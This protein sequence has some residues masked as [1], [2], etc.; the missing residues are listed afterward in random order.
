MQRRIFLRLVAQGAVLSSC[1]TMAS[2]Q[3]A[4]TIPHGLKGAVAGADDVLIIG[5]GMA[6]LAAAQALKVAGKTV[7]IIEA[8]QRVG[9][10]VWSWRNWGAPIELVP[11]GSKQLLATRLPRSLNKPI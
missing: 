10:R 7:R 4:P 11:I 6:G 2:Q 8:R 5:A 3:V 9:G 1:G